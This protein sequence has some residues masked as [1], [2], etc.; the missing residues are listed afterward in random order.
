M[1]W[2][3]WYLNDITRV[4]NPSAWFEVRTWLRILYPYNAFNM[5]RVRVNVS[6]RYIL[7]TV[8]CPGRCGTLRRTTI[9]YEVLAHN[10][11]DSR[12]VMCART[13]V[14]QVDYDVYVHL[15]SLR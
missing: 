12:R 8:L 13:C 14:F 15:F 1:R 5:F 9:A 4:M 7:F 10:E 2:A 11:R 3:H 6:E